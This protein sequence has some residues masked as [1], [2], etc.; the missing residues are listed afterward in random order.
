M[1]CCVPE[2][3]GR[4]LCATRDEIVSSSV[5]DPFTLEDTISSRVAQ[6]L[7]PNLSGTQQ[8]MLGRRYTQNQEAWRDYLRGRYYA[9]RYTEEGFRKGLTYF[10]RAIEED[11]SYALA[12][13]GLAFSYYAASNLLLPPLEAMAKS[14]AAA[15]R[16]AALDD[17]LAEA[18]VS[19]GI[20]ASKFDWDWREAEAQFEKALSLDPNSANAH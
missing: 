5:T 15:Q 13:S 4:R 18:H 7:L 14:K 6:S 8:T 16:S 10:Q 2:R 9:S 3:F 12:Y 17:T 19:L 1:V 20:V 11:P